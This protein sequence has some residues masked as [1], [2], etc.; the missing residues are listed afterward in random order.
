MTDSLR[1]RTEVR[2]TGAELWRFLDGCG[3]AGIRLT[4]VRA[5]DEFTCTVSLRP[6][7]LP[8]AKRL[9]ERTGCHITVLRNRGAAAAA[10]RLRRK[11]ALLAGL[12]IMA[13]LLC[14]SGLFVW[15]IRVAFN[16]SSISDGRILRVLA[17]QGVGVGSF[18]PAFRGERIRTR[19]LC[20]L[21]ELSFLAVN[22]RGC[23][24]EVTARAAVPPPEIWTA[25]EP[26]D[27]TARRSGVIA[28][29]AV[30]S[31]REQVSRGDAVVPGQ[32]LI[33]GTAAEPHA[34]GEI[35]AYTFYELTAA[36]PLLQTVKTPTGPARRRFALIV[37]EQ[38]INFYPGSGILPP[39][40]DKMTKEIPLGFGNA[41]SLP[42]RWITETRQSYTLTVSPA[43]RETL[44]RRLESALRAQLSGQLGDGGEPVRVH[45][46]FAD[47]GQV[48][49][50]T[51]RAEC[52]ERIDWDSPLAATR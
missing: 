5:E 30:L 41:F 4:D 20:T 10:R 28:S 49:T 46:T 7:D 26:G 24:A 33:A 36:A 18:Y 17:Q 22:V 52:L 15:D 14:A 43:D 31:G 8:A 16:D 42:V 9:A 37:G 1:S 50:A 12:A 27:V 3:R 39:E 25:A 45:M 35:R 19:A 32:V 2:V 47:D 29:M 48:L 23:R 34:R 21:P 6:R 40:C 11:R 13:A 44:E 51:L 38:R